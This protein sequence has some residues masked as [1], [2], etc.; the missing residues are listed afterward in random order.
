VMFRADEGLQG[1]LVD[2][3]EICLVPAGE[4]PPEHFTE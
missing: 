4:Q 2:L 1:F 3:R